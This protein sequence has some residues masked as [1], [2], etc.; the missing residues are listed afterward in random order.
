MAKYRVRVGDTVL[1]WSD[2]TNRAKWP[3]GIVKKTYPGRDR[4]IHAVQLSNSKGVIEHTVQH[5]YPLEWQRESTVPAGA[6]QWLYHDAPIFR[7]RRATV[8]VAAAKIK[9]IA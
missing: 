7:P 1:V 4:H 6:E 2:S 9:E 3:L 8:A 5:L